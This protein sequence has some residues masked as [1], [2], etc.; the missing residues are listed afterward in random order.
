[1]IE[2]AL[3]VPICHS[4]ISVSYILIGAMSCALC[5][6]YSTTGILCVIVMINSTVIIHASFP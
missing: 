6:R 3:R 1:M 2:L 5:F 4:E